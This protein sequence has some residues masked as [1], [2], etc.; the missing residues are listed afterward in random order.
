MSNITP[1]YFHGN[2]VRTLK[3]EDGK[4]LFVA[5]DVAT[6]LGYQNTN[7]AITKYCDEGVAKPLPPF[8]L[9]AA[10]KNFG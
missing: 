10:L 4:P 3:D 2:Q 6:V 9:P 8:K 5:K 7:E 1:F